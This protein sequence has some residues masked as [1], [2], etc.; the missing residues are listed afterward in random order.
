MSLCQ[1]AFN[2][3]AI[4]GNRDR[5]T[6]GWPLL[7]CILESV[8][9]HRNVVGQLAT[10]WTKGSYCILF[11]SLSFRYKTCLIRL[12][13][14]YFWFTVS[15]LNFIVFFFFCILEFWKCALTIFPYLSL[16]SFLAAEKKRR[17][18]EAQ[19][20]GPNASTQSNGTV[21]LLLLYK[22][23]FLCLLLH[24]LIRLVLVL[25]QQLCDCNTEFCL[26][27]Q[28]TSL[29]LPYVSWWCFWI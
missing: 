24:Y 14:L 4:L 2:T 26:S 25:V 15:G 10:I 18:E 9:L 11:L 20:S 13:L 12:A 5:N 21:S 8:L 22:L 7:F 6:Q 1:K 19:Q 29:S 16:V 27:Y 17:A 28:T 3:I 23:Y